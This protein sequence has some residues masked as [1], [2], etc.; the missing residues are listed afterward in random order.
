MFTHSVARLLSGI[1]F[2]G[3]LSACGSGTGESRQVPVG[4]TA[5]SPPG[6]GGSGSL[7]APVPLSPVNGEQLSTL[8]PTL[9]VQNVA[10]TAQGARTYEFQISDRTDFSLGPTLTASFI[11][12][13]SQT[14]VAEG[15]DGRTS[16][17]VGQ[18]LQPT[19]RMYWRSRVVQGT[20]ASSWSQPATFRTKL[21]GY[22]RAGELYD[23]LIHGETIGTPEG[24]YT[25]IAGKGIQLHDQRSYVRYRLEQTITSG[26]FSVEVEGLYAGAP[27]QK[28]KIFSMLNGE[29]NLLKSLY[30]ANVQYRGGD[31]ANPN[32][33]ISFK[34]LYGSQSRKFEPDKAH[35]TVHILDSSR[36]YFWKATWGSEFRLLVQEGIGGPTIYDHGEPTSGTYNPSPHY[37]YLGANNRTFDPGNEEGTRPGIVIRNVWVGSRPRPA[38]LGNALD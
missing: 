29:G 34:A 15:S 11:V 3:F 28:L 14:G 36:T 16:L 35:R 19:T 18:D 7:S 8:R 24:S 32:N 12:S 17:A 9:T 31:D 38:T 20:A 27:G 10:S 33:S 26:E 23:P 37:A 21:I 2:C 22:S 5:P 13:V 6:G 30:M 25:F 4:P 1:V